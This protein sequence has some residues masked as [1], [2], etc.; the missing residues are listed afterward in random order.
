MLSLCLPEGHKHNPPADLLK[1]CLDA[2]LH[3][4]ND[5]KS[6]IENKGKE[7]KR[8]DNLWGRLTDYLTKWCG[9]LFVP[10]AV[11][12]HDSLA[13]S[14]TS[15]YENKGYMPLVQAFNHALHALREIDV[16]LRKSTRE[17]T[18]LLLFHRNDLKNI[19]SMH[20]GRRS[21]RKPDLILVS[22]GVA[23]KDAFSEERADYAFEKA[24]EPPENNFEW[25]GVQA[26]CARYDAPFSTANVCTHASKPPP[27]PPPPP[28]P[29][30]TP[31]KR[32]NA[33]GVGCLSTLIQQG[34]VT[35]RQ[36]DPSKSYCAGYRCVDPNLDP[37]LHYSSQLV[38]AP[39]RSTMA[40]PLQAK[41]AANSAFHRVVDNTCTI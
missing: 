11:H 41:A 3:I 26:S 20:D 9:A 2:V 34:L 24:G 15:N 13:H 39:S 30:P 19:L 33:A 23:K 12:L 7:Q 27:P 32:Q 36:G 17:S 5:Q 29:T 6:P 31:M 25:G 21:R 18:D 28:P 16:P 22:L 38:K 4:C 37:N 8:G 35:R 14:R 1:R 40:K 10:P